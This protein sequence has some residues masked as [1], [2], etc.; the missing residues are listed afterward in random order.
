[1]VKDPACEI[2]WHLMVRTSVEQLSLMTM[3]ALDRITGLLKIP[4]IAPPDSSPTVKFCVKSSI[5][6]L[7]AFLLII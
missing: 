2:W 3:R 4:I 1:M 6:I 7:Q 5:C